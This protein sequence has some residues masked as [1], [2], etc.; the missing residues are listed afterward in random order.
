MNINEAKSKV[1]N[2]N[3]HDFLLCAFNVGDF[4]SRAKQMW[5]HFPSTWTV[6]LTWEELH[7]ATR[8]NAKVRYIPIKLYRHLTYSCHTHW[9]GLVHWVEIWIRKLRIANLR[10]PPF[11]GELGGKGSR[12]CF[13]STEAGRLYID[14]TFRPEQGKNYKWRMR[15]GKDRYK[16]NKGWCLW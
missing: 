4:I 1:S 3:K 10:Q 5:S 2:K 8:G 14:G 9:V 16:M 7:S 11:S 12:G 13:N 6:S 15:G